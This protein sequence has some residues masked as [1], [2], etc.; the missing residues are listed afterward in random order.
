VGKDEEATGASDGRAPVRDEKCIVDDVCLVERLELLRRNVNLSAQ[1]VLFA[2]AKP[3]LQTV[4]I[5]PVGR[6]PLV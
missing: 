4:E 6:V 2:V 1:G 3:Q 5:T